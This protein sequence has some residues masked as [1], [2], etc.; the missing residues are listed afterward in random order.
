MRVQVR[1]L[2]E[3]GKSLP[4]SAVKALAPHVGML[5]VREVRDLELNRA[6]LQAR[7]LDPTRQ[8]ETDLLPSL[9]DA[10]MLFLEKGELRLTG[11]ERSDDLEVPQ[12]W[13]VKVD[14]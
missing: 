3:K 14:D 10:K 13:D 2:R 6:V 9:E 11:I 12:T 8:T 5:R 7:L 1:P 4:A